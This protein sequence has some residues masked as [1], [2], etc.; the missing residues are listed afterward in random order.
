MTLVSWRRPNCHVTECHMTLQVSH[1]TSVTVTF[2]VSHD[3]PPEPVMGRAQKLC[4]RLSA[5]GAATGG[6]VKKEALPAGASSKTLALQLAWMLKNKDVLLRSR[7]PLA[8]PVPNELQ[9]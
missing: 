2:E 6:R 7:C 9:W 8:A 1:D 3:A 5:T 4:Q